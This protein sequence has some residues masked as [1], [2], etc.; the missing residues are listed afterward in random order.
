MIPMV[1]FSPSDAPFNLGYAIAKVQ[2]LKAGIYV[3]MN[4]KAFNPEEVTKLLYKGKF[5]SLFG[6]RSVNK[7]KS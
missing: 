1:G 2:E 4:G 7:G 3:C 5:V 6:E